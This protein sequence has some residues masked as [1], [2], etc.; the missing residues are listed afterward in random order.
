MENSWLDD[1]TRQKA[2]GMIIV[3]ILL[4]FIYIYILLFQK[5]IRMMKTIKY[6]I[7]YHEEVI[8]EEKMKTYHERF[9]AEEMNPDSFIE[10]QVNFEKL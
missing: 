8:D 2:I 4:I 1:K 3:F 6:N 10:N 7:G 5:A 9:L